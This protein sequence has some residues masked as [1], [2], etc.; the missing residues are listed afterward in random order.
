[1]RALAGRDSIDISDADHIVT[2]RGLIIQ[3][4]RHFPDFHS[5]LFDANN[6]LRQDVP[7]FVN[8]RNPRLNGAMEAPLQPDDIISLFSPLSSGKLN[9]EALREP[10]TRK[11]K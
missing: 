4:V 5:Q 10:A 8:G 9:I 1:M 3:L 6:N 2:L 11:R 7:I